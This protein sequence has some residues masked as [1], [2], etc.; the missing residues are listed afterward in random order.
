MPTMQ[1]PGC[2]K[3]V[4]FEGVAGVCP[5]CASVVRA[6]RSAAPDSAGGNAGGAVAGGGSRRSGG[7]RRS[8][9][10]LTDLQQVAGTEEVFT[11]P[12]GSAPS[13]GGGFGAFLSGL[14]PRVLWGT[15]AG[16]ALVLGFGAWSVLHTPSAT[17]APPPAVAPPMTGPIAT[18]TPP[19]PPPPPPPADV[20]PPESIATTGPAVAALPAWYGLHP[21]KPVL[22]PEKINDEKVERAL[23]LGA[24]YLKPRVAIGP[25]KDGGIGANGPDMVE[26]ATCLATYALLHTGEAL[27]DNDL[28]SSSAYMKAALQRMQ[29]LD[30]P[31]AV[32]TYTYSLRAQTLGLADREA[33][34]T[35]LQRDLAWL[36]K[37]EHNGSYTY[38][39]PS[40]PS[41]TV[42]DNSNSQYGVLGVWAASEAGL[43]VPAKYWEECER[44]WVA[45]QC[46]DGGWAYT[47]KQG[48]TV[49]MVAA[50]VTTLSVAIEQV[51][52]INTGHK[53]HGAPTAP[54]PPPARQREGKA[55]A[56]PSDPPVTTAQLTGAIDRGLA[57][58][59]KGDNLLNSGEDEGYTLY[60]IERAAL[61]TG[62]RYFGDHDWYRELG[63]AQI[64][65]QGKDDGSWGDK[66]GPD[67][68]TSFRLLFL[69]RGR[70]PL[71]MNKLKFAGDWNDRPRDVAKLV[72]FTSA[73]LERPFAWG[74]ADLDRDWW[75]WL[76]APM[77]FLTTDAPVDL[78]DAQ[79]QKL[80]AYVDAGGFLLVHN[81][82]NN[83]DVDAWAKG[84]AKRIIPGKQL[85]AVPTTDV[86]YRA[87]YPLGSGKVPPPPLMQLTNGVRPLIVYSPTDLSKA[88]LAW[89]AKSKSTNVDLQLGLNLFVAAAGKSDYRNRLK[90]PYLDPST[91]SPVGT[92][93]VQQLTYGGGGNPVPE[94][95]AY[96]RFGRWFIDQTSIALDVQLTDLKAVTLKTGPVAVLSGTGTVDFAKADVSGLRAFV[97]GGGTLLVDADGGDKAFAKSVREGLLTSAFGGVAPAAMPVTNPIMAGGDACM[98][99]L[100]DGPRLR[101]YA[102][103]QLG[104][105]HPP[106]P[107]Y[108]IYGSGTVIVCDLDCTTA[109]LHT[110]TYGILGYTPDYADALYKNAI[111]W[112]LSRFQ[113]PPP[114]PATA[115]T[116]KQPGKTG[117]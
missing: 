54:P 50:G 80:R 85:E 41:D 79:V 34:Q 5:N 53:G 65:S 84:L 33:D 116:V 62:Y 58:L 28:K 12:P 100:A 81:E 101:Q 1:C 9:S 66:W 38:T 70:Q 72:G 87:L 111:L 92:V 63:A 4:R 15:A 8:A 39:L 105:A 115:P 24:N 97:H 82:F 74:V 68:G 106:V 83:K 112:T 37:G 59:A 99:S 27:D 75:T 16:L 91:V 43:S 2:G 14:D 30:I 103:D 96:T 10:S 22:P 57:Y 102:S 61:A 89:R 35:E 25:G 98:T 67:I 107:Q 48:S 6:P 11:P 77:V 71:L 51:V 60:G 110:G 21:V 3:T 90:T 88:W 13:G 7:G 44:H 56:A 52:T 36:L 64:A 95:G 69:A 31:P 29:H 19:L 114:P 117:V 40:A 45:Q 20:P 23:R 47:G 109:L 108:F 55:G 93:P 86:L 76:D 42:W 17:V 32:A 73:Q 78:S 104:N 49:P 26:G 113:P 46:D 18:N 94:P